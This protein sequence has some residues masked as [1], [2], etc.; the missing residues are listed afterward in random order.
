MLRRDFLGGVISSVSAFSVLPNSSKAQTMGPWSQVLIPE[1][2]NI[3]SDEPSKPAIIAV[4]GRCDTTIRGKDLFN[5]PT[6]LVVHTFR[7][8][9]PFGYLAGA[10]YDQ[11]GEYSWRCTLGPPPGFEEYIHFGYGDRIVS[12][13]NSHYRG[14]NWE[15]MPD[16][17][18]AFR[19]YLS[20]PGLFK[21][22]AWFKA[23]AVLLLRHPEFVDNQN[24]NPQ[25]ILN[26]Y[27][28]QIDIDNP[29]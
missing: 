18:A 27:Y 26:H 4:I 16:G 25:D 22:R 8:I 13:T 29:W 11:E 9:H 7:V 10:A 14:K 2:F 12:V 24:T 17:K 23:D 21:G 5:L 20:K 28:R 3:S 19:W 1:N 6:E 15:V